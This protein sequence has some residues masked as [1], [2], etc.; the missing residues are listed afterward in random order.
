M[1]R[2]QLKSTNREGHEEHEEHNL[3]RHPLS[4]Q[5]VFSRQQRLR[6]S[7]DFQEVFARGE[8]AADNVL[9]VHAMRSLRKSKMGISVS[10]K[11]GGAVIRN[12]WKRLIREAF[13]LNVHRLPGNL[14]LVVRPRRGAHPDLPAVASSLIRLSQKLDRRALPTLQDG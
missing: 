13:R 3:L 5:F 1:G 11:V 9:V 7:K 8:V 4:R 2:G 6:S 10:R 12:R 14:A